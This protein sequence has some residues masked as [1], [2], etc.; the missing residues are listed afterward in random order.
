MANLKENTG[1]FLAC[2]KP[3]SGNPAV[4]LQTGYIYLS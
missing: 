3:G 4:N 1:L 2:G